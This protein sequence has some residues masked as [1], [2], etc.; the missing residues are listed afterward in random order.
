MKLASLFLTRKS[1]SFHEY[2]AGVLLFDGLESVP[3]TLSW[4]SDRF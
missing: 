3:V 1:A 2:A 4:L